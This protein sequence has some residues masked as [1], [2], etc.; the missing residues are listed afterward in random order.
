MSLFLKP[1]FSI[2][3]EASFLLNE[4][5]RNRFWGFEQMDMP[6]GVEK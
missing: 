5:V 6:C 3:S 1:T 4:G 2:K